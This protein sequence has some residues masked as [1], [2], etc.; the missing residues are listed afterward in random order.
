M[1][2][3]LK[4]RLPLTLKQWVNAASGQNKAAAK[5]AAAK[6]NKAVEDQ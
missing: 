2:L 3:T 1:R 6:I 4:L 5:E